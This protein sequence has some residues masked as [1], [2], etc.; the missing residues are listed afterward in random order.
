MASLQRDD[1]RPIIRNSDRLYQTP[2]RT[3]TAD[4]SGGH[5]TNGA[6]S[7]DWTFSSSCHHIFPHSDSQGGGEGEE[8]G[9]I[10]A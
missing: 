6:T 1:E 7:V 4:V 9:V 3:E 10:A 2:Q 5:T 8:P